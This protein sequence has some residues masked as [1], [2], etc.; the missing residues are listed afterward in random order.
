MAEN[1]A[2][3]IEK[4]VE[5]GRAREDV[6][7]LSVRELK[8][9]IAEIEGN[10]DTSDAGANEDSSDAEY[11]WV[12]GEVYVD[13]LARLAPG[14]YHLES[15]T[16]PERLRKH[17]AVVEFLGATIAPRKLGDIAAWAKVDNSRD[18]E[19]AVLVAKLLKPF[20]TY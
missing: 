9:A 17:G 10:G 15:K 20:S 2:S 8:A 4:L 6:E 14:L 19:D 13:Q 12:K 1:K 18:V 16:I 11:V 3:L 5:L 7:S